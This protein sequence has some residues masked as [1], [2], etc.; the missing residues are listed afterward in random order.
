LDI[1]RHTLPVLTGGEDS[2]GESRVAAATR[3]CGFGGGGADGMT[4]G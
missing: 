2:G 1:H 3:R 4:W